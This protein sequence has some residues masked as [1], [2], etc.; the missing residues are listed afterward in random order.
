MAESRAAR[1]S[2]RVARHAKH[3]SHGQRTLTGD[4]FF[5][6][7]VF[8]PLL[9]LP[10]R[11]HQNSE[12]ARAAVDHQTSVAP[13]KRTTDLTS[14]SLD[15]NKPTAACARPSSV[16]V[17]RSSSSVDW[18]AEDKKDWFLAAATAT[19]QEALAAGRPPP[20]PPTPTQA[21]AFSTELSADASSE[22]NLPSVSDLRVSGDSLGSGS[23]SGGGG[24]SRPEGPLHIW[25]P[26]AGTPAADAAFME[27]GRGNGNSASPPRSAESDVELVSPKGFWRED[28]ETIDARNA[29][30]RFS[31]WE[32]GGA[33]GKDEDSP[34]EGASGPGVVLREGSGG[35]S[36]R[37]DR[38]GGGRPPLRKDGGNP[39]ALEDQVDPTVKI[40]RKLFSSPEK[41]PQ[42]PQRR[43]TPP[44]AAA[45]ATAV[46]PPKSSSALPRAGGALEAMVEDDHESPSPM[47]PPGGGPH[48]PPFWATSIEPVRDAAAGGGLGFREEEKEG[49]GGAGPGLGWRRGEA[50]LVIPEPM[51]QPKPR[52]VTI[53]SVVPQRASRMAGE[54]Q[55]GTGGGSGGGGGDPGGDAERPLAAPRPATT[56][57]TLPMAGEHKSRAPKELQ[58]VLTP[59]VKIVRSYSYHGLG[60]MALYDSSKRG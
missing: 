21:P 20:P 43:K 58:R 19:H 54:A 40:G 53:Q 50:G 33:P 37:A 5:F 3:P 31:G 46:K 55:Q 38:A 22:E 12:L 45:A 24:G 42:P 34:A 11:T 29:T 9:S 59:G 8:L 36:S 44:S 13:S 28:F 35:S 14:K 27:E 16:P 10:H 41:P 26:G 47:G 17:H 32:D 25:A 23:G 6:M 2:R 60:S 49:A 52:S 57:P 18:A 1:K 30:R 48:P 15:A 7:I 56:S 39:A 4:I 51:P